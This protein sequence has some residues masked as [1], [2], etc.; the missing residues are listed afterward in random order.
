MLFL[1]E[2][3]GKGLNEYFIDMRGLGNCT[4]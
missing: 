3:L 1:F 2:W 4:E